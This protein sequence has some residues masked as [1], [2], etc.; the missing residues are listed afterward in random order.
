MITEPQRLQ[1]LEA[2]GL[3]AW[4]ARYRLPNARPTDACE[5][6]LPERPVAKPPAERLHALLDEAEAASSRQSDPDPVVAEAPR[7]ATI[8]RARQLLGAMPENGNVV[9]AENAKA[10]PDE[11]APR[12]EPLRFVL[13]VACLGDRWLIVVPEASPPDAAQIQLLGNALQA[14]GIVPDRL[15]AFQ[16]FR[17]PLMEE[18]SVISP[19][20]EARE[21]LHAFI[22]G[23]RRRGWAPERVLIFGREETIDR[24]L[25]IEQ[26]HCGPLA[27][28]GWQGPAL[29]ELAESAEAK[30]SLWPT[31]LEWQ[32]AWSQ[33]PEANADA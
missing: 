5:W 12:Q 19:L 11:V 9:P 3:T 33:G 1:Y 16:T 32:R 18:L 21:G 23:T 29:A 15:P 10:V 28:P 30:R 6:E 22:D 13:Q 8:G 26:G 4:V 25:S 20:E 24:V 7:P 14:V 27:M 17:W 2:M 31:L